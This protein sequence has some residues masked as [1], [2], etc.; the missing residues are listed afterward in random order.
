MYVSILPPCGCQWILQ[1]QAV[2]ISQPSSCTDCLQ[3]ILFS[4]KSWCQH[5]KH[6]Q[7]TSSCD[8]SFHLFS[9]T[10]I[11]HRHSLKTSDTYYISC[12]CDT[13]AT[14]TAVTLFSVSLFQVVCHTAGGF[15]SSAEIKSFLPAWQ[16]DINE[17]A[18]CDY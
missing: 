2:G 11:Q 18:C 6:L 3:G 5:W 14:P 8:L 1:T 16:L 12:S 13:P 15:W 10:Q 7:I 17:T 4:P 9:G